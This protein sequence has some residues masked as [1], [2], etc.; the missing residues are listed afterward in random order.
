[1]MKIVC[2]TTILWFF[3]AADLSGA[4]FL[5]NFRKLV[6][7]PPKPSHNEKAPKPSPSE[8]KYK[9][10]QVQ[11]PVESSESC[12][13]IDMRCSDSKSMTACIQRFDDGLKLLVLLI[14]NQ[15]ESNMKVNLTIPNSADKQKE[16]EI[17]KK[18]TQKIK[19]TL[20]SLGS[21][22]ILL[23][24]GNDDCVLHL[25]RPISLGN[26]I[27]RL[28]SD[29]KLLTPIYGAY[30]LLA[31]T[32]IA[33]GV[34]ACCKFRR[35]KR[36]GEIPYQELEMGMPESSI[37]AETAEGWD[38]G[39]DDDWDEDKAV[40]SPGPSHPG[41]ISANGLTSRSANRDGWENWDG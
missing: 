5:W 21:T 25:E 29:L 27:K 26:F 8:E 28:P 13:G 19:V 1:M 37:N 7:L 12:D 34:W 14:Q 33:G 38:L 6:A 41:S 39:W 10:K 2:L 35:R 3:V 11:G 16:I 22:K 15:G 23:N 31:M 4:D 24:A 36:H 30:F 20:D 40:K 18:Q 9:G 17:L 32:L